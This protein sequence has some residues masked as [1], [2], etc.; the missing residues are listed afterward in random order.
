[1]TRRLFLNRAAAL[2]AVYATAT[3]LVT[4][5]GMLRAWKHRRGPMASL[6]IDSGLILLSVGGFAAVLDRA[7]KQPLGFDPAIVQLTAVHFHFAAFVLLLLTGLAS[8]PNDR[9]SQINCIAVIVAV[10]LVAIGITTSRLGAS[11]SI[12]CVAAWC[13]A[14]GGLMTAD[15]APFPL[16]DRSDAVLWFVLA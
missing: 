10:P 11:P 12:E 8:K 5:W 3:L 14:I 1:M 9:L 15:C 13:M 7:G 6:C 4:A 2:A 16:D